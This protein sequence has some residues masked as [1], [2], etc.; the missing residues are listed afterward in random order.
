MRERLPRPHRT[1]RAKGHLYLS[2]HEEPFGLPDFVTSA[3]DDA[4]TAANA[5]PVDAD[6]AEPAF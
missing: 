3:L 2:L 4:Y 1:A 6:P 5:S